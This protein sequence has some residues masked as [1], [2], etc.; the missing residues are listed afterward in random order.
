VPSHRRN[1]LRVV[2]CHTQC[3]VLWRCGGLQEVL[4]NVVTRHGTEYYSVRHGVSRQQRHATPPAPGVQD[5]RFHMLG[6]SSARPA[7]ML[8]ISAVSPKKIAE[9][10]TQPA[11]NNIQG[12]TAGSVHRGFLLRMERFLLSLDSSK[13]MGVLLPGSTCPLHSLRSDHHQV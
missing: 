4:D 10:K 12:L 13:G 1:R 5:S 2:S 8:Q 6:N 3:A 9:L 11:R 7:L